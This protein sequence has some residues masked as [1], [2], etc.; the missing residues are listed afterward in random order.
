MERAELLAWIVD[1]LNDR[2]TDD[3]THME[4]VSGEDGRIYVHV[5]MDDDDDDE[6]Y[7]ATLRATTKRPRA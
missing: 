4:C 5:W 2:D 3:G 6:P 1:C 7:S